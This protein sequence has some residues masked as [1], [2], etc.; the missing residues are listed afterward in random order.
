MKT[1]PNLSKL[2]NEEQIML[3]TFLDKDSNVK[4]D[5][6]EP[7]R[8]FY[9]GEYKKTIDLIDHRLNSNGADDQLLFLKGRS[10]LMLNEHKKATEIFLDAIALNEKSD[11]F[12]GLGYAYMKIKNSNKAIAAFNKAINLDNKNSFAYFNAGLLLEKGKLYSEAIRY[13]YSAGTS[14]ILTKNFQ[15]V[16]NVK[17]ALKRLAKFDKDAVFKVKKIDNILDQFLFNDDKKYMITKLKG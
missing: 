1:L 11:Y 10:L 8:L 4:L 12:N 13:Y 6:N 14:S 16:F 15:R 3:S 17:I 9:N 2:N 5:I 7:I